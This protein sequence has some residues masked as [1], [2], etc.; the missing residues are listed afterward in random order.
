M[1]QKGFHY[2]PFEVRI[3]FSNLFLEVKSLN[4]EAKQLSSKY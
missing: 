1:E 3:Q 4:S 2:I